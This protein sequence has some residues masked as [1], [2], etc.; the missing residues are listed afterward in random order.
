MQ[1]IKIMPLTHSFQHILCKMVTTSWFTQ[2]LKLY[3]YLCLFYLE[4]TLVSVTVGYEAE[5]YT[6]MESEER[7]ELSIVITNPPSGAPTS[8]TLVLSTYDHTAGREDAFHE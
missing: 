3:I 6:A 5:M 1:S 7:V 2:N 8:F 4:F